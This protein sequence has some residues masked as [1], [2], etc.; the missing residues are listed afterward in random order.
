MFNGE[1][2]AR[3]VKIFRIEARQAKSIARREV[4]DGITQI[5]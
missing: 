1:P 5:F 4:G 3:I 2:F